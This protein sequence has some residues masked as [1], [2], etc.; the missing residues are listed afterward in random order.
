[1]KKL[2]H[3]PIVYQIVHAL[4]SSPLGRRTLVQRTGITEMTVRTHL[5][6]LR[7][8]GYV[9]MAKGGTALTP[10]GRA[11]FET[12]LERVRH[13]AA[14]K[15]KDLALDRYNAAALLRRVGDGFRESWRY[16][17]AAV[18][19]GASGVLLLVQRADG[20]RLSDDPAPLG[21]Q[22]PRDA[23]YL[24]R[25]FDAQPQDGVVVA[26]G[27]TPRAAR[28]GLWSVLVEF[29]PIQLKKEARAL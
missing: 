21:R 2:G 22:N 29:L 1:M 3:W 17:D 19:E 8:A 7:E 18:R 26:F 4:D 6:K 20:W 15:L 25:V 24:E 28:G 11:A 14:L 23:A 9:T 10:A 5:N 27:P 16:R 13:V 12:L